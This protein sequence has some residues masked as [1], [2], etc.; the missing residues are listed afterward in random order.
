M[1]GAEPVW[2]RDWL[3]LREHQREEGTS[4]RSSPSGADA[5]PWSRSRSG[6]GSEDAAGAAVHTADVPESAAE[7]PCWWEILGASGLHRAVL[8]TSIGACP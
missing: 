4:I 6:R 2:A 3:T 5:I 8:A 7:R 1:V